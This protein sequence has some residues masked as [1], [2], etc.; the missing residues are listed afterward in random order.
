MRSWLLAFGL[1]LLANSQMRSYNLAIVDAGPL[2]KIIN[3]YC[4]LE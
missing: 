2:K 1:W 4:K 3:E